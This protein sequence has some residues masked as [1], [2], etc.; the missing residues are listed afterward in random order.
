MQE[1]NAWDRLA[2]EPV[3]WFSRFERF[4]L[5]GPTRSVLSVY[6]AE[7]AREGAK[8]RNGLP[9]SWLRAVNRYRW[10]ERADAWDEY[11][12]ERDRQEHEALRQRGI[13]DRQNRLDALNDIFNRMKA[14]I[15]AR[16]ASPLFAA[17]P[18]GSTG[19]LALRPVLL[20]VYKDAGDGALTPTRESMLVYD[21]RVDV[22]LL[23]QMLDYLKHVAIEVGDWNERREVSGSVPATIYVEREVPAFDHE[24]Y[25][26]AWQEGRDRAAQSNPHADDDA[27]PAPAMAK[28]GGA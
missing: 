28:A 7:V 1:P 27:A 20:K 26:R 5:A 16:A 19:L 25:A 21:A 8:R 23:R 9:S 10:R 12:I 3:L 11:E 14:V 22:A 4:R 13:A 15:D 24:A 17:F 2:G 18:G 6:H